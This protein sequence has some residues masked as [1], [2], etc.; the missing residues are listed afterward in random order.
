[1]IDSPQRDL[2]KLR[3]AEMLDLAGMVVMGGPMSANDGEKLPFI[4]EELRLIEEAMQRDLPFLGIC[5]GS[6]MLAKA[7]GSRVYRGPRKEI[8]WYPLYLKDS[9]RQDALLAGLPREMP[10]FQWHGETFEL[11]AGAQRLA[12]S[13]LYPNQGFRFGNKAYGFQFH[14]EMTGEMVRQWLAEGKQEI[15]AADLP[16][17]AAEIAG[18]TEKNLKSLQPF[19]AAVAKGFSSLLK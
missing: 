6:Q 16:H 18:S 9:A 3:L 13:D 4:R 5:L 8:G 17:S 2:S 19:V 1:M 12:S 10:M 14:P 7:L 15:A 11:P